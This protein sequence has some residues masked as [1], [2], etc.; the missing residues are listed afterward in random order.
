MSTLNTFDGSGYVTPELPAGYMVA[1]S[2]PQAQ[3]EDMRN[4][5][6]YFREVGGETDVL[7]VQCENFLISLYKS[8]SN[9]RLLQLFV[10]RATSINGNL[11]IKWVSRQLALSFSFE[12]AL[13][14]VGENVTVTDAFDTAADITQVNQQLA[15]RYIQIFKGT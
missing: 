12:Q 7:L 10:C 3:L 8:L 5:G 14:S 1:I 6:I 13:K 15:S 9:Q 11:K 2:T 4:N